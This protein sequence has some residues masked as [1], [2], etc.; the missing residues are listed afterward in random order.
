MAFSAAA[1]LPL[2][3]GDRNI[4]APFGAGEDAALDGQFIGCVREDGAQAFPHAAGLSPGKHDE[5]GQQALERMQPDP[6]RGHHAEVAAAA[7]KGPE[8]LRLM[9][10]V[11][12]DQ[13][14]IGEDE[15]GGEQVVQGEAEAAVERAVTA[16]QG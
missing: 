6:D 1:G 8:Q 14:S 4:A 7:A 16:D 5:P 2:Q 11:C 12:G 9:R 3:A 15:L 13:P 10:S